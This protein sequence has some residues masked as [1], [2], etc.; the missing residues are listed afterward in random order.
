MTIPNLVIFKLEVGDH[1]EGDIPVKTAHD[2]NLNVVPSG[3]TVGQTGAR[4]NSQ[5]NISCFTYFDNLQLWWQTKFF[6][7]DDTDDF[8]QSLEGV[9]DSTMIDFKLSNTVA[10]KTETI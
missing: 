1:P 3:H 10:F 9:D 6:Y 5:S 4:K 8:H 7:K 2:I